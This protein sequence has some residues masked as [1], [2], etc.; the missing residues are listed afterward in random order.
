MSFCNLKPNT[1]G[2]LHMD[3]G[4]TGCRANTPVTV[5]SMLVSSFLL[6]SSHFWGGTQRAERL[7][8]T[9]NTTDSVAQ[10]NQDVKLTNN[11]P[12]G[13]NLNLNLPVSCLQV[14]YTF[15]KDGFVT[16]YVSSRPG[17]WQNEL[18]GT[19]SQPG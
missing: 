2:P 12:L 18:A 6:G 4:L 1:V 10:E 11:F 13:L 8:V 3:D 17:F 15:V 7:K 19:S 5:P 9:F 16:S 14:R